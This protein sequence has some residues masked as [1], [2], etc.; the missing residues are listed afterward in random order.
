MLIVYK[1]V[2]LPAPEPCRWCGDHLA[3]FGAG[4]SDRADVTPMCPTCARQGASWLSVENWRHFCQR[5]VA[6]EEGLSDA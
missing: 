2:R 1:V 3:R 5:L 6:A 4:L